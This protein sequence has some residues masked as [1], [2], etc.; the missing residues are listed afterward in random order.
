MPKITTTIIPLRKALKWAAIA[1]I[2][3]AFI[4]LTIACSSVIYTI[5]N[6]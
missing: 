2:T 1:L 3:L 5:Q 4:V 6:H